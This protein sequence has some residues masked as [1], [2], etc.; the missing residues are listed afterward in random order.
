M[1]PKCR[2]ND[3]YLWIDQTTK[4]FFR[5]RD[6]GDHWVPIDHHCFV[7]TIVVINTTSLAP[8]TM[9]SMS[10]PSFFDSCPPCLFQIYCRVDDAKIHLLWRKIESLEMVSLKLWELFVNIVWK[11][12][13]FQY[14]PLCFFLFMSKIISFFTL[15]KKGKFCSVHYTLQPSNYK[16]S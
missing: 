12:A 15:L 8:T 3:M 11:T 13:T 10:L 9:T 14:L 7:L 5:Q 2:D 4:F 6:D 16:L 1:D